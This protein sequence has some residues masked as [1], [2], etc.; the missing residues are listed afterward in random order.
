MMRSAEGSYEQCGF[1]AHEA[2]II[3]PSRMMASWKVYPIRNQHEHPRH[4]YLMSHLDQVA[5]FE[6]M[7]RN[8]M[9]LW[10]AYHTHPSR[11]FA[12]SPPDMHDWHYPTDLKMVV[13]T[14]EAVAVWEFD[15][16]SFTFRKDFA[17]GTAR[18]YDPDGPNAALRS[19]E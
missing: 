8:K 13:V 1:I 14:T 18:D 10:G 17:Y 15:G 16:E 6:D 2:E 9:K 12:P 3:L 19:S 11:S 5:A 7:A 4:N